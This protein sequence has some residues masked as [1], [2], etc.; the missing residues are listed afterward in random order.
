MYSKWAANGV[1]VDVS[2]RGFGE[3]EER[4]RKK[5]CGLNASEVASFL[6]DIIQ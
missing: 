3:R 6:V 1:G 2:I 5:G 4:R